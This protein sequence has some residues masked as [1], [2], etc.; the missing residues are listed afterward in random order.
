ME[1][2][3][4]SLPL[5]KSL[6]IDHD[7]FIQLLTFRSI[8]PGPGLVLAKVKSLAMDPSH[9]ALSLTTT[10]KSSFA[11]ASAFPVTKAPILSLTIAS[12]N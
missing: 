8:P 10:S 9:R 11:V 7:F 6:I 5:K 2:L 12:P 3:V 4:F 1:T